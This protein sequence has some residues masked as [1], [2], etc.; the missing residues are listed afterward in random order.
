MSRRWEQ[1]A[2]HDHGVGQNC[3]G[4]QWRFFPVRVQI[5]SQHSVVKLLLLVLQTCYWN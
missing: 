2:S 3:E 5:F 1:E 4:P